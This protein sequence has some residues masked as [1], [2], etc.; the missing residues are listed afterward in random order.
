MKMTASLLF[1][2]TLLHAAPLSALERD[3]SLMLFGGSY[4]TGPFP[5]LTLIP[6]ADDPEGTYLLGAAYRK[7]LYTFNY[8]FEMGF[9]VGAAARFGD[10]FSGE[11][12]GGPYLRHEGLTLGPITISPGFVAGLSA[13][14]SAMGIEK[15]RERRYDG[16]ATLLFYL[17][18]ELSFTYKAWP[19]LELVVRTH[20]R[21]GEKGTLGNFGEGHNANVFGIRYK[22]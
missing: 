6:Y 14:S 2:A 8:G 4:M 12:F 17:G 16:D 1:A 22:F 20:H 15:A 9:E 7:E 18:P 11:A 5:G 21:S 19:N 10:G 13:V 3:Q